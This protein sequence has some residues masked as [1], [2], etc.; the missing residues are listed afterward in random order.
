[1]SFLLIV[2]HLSALAAGAAVTLAFVISSVREREMRSAKVGGALFCVLVMGLVG[3]T[4]LG[5]V[6]AFEGVPGLVL[7]FSGLSLEAAIASLFLRTSRNAKALAGTSGY[8]VDHVERFDERDHVFARNRPPSRALDYYREFYRQHPE[9]EPVDAKRREKGH[10]GSIGSLDRPGERPNVA[11]TLSCL[12]KRDPLGRSRVTRPTPDPRCE[13]TSLKWTPEEATL[14]TKGLLRHLG[15]DLVGITK[16]NPQWVYSHRGDM[17]G[18]D[19]AEWGAE[20]GIEH[21]YAIVFA[22]EMSAEMVATAPHTPSMVETCNVYAKMAL[23]ATEMAGFISNLGYSASANHVGYYETVL[24]PLAV[25]AGL[26]EVGR[27]G[28]LMTAQFG[29][30][31]RLAC[32]TTDLPLVVDR[33]I[34]IGVEDF[35]RV[36]KKCAN[37]CP[38]KSI[39]T[40]DLTVVN[41]SLR[42]KLNAETCFEQWARFGTDCNVCMRVCPWSHRRTWPHRMI[43]WLA[44]RN[45]W[46]RRVLSYL[47]DVFYG[48]HP[49]PAAPPPWAE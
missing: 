22:V 33:P 45:G 17:H 14:R 34:D 9:L 40:D 41:G 38:S 23:M 36:C 25:D 18:G 32:V 1:M 19:T 44:T 37:C 42:W 2:I 12:S 24:V 27:L 13:T 8:L 16:L 47:D 29:P 49:R 15:A 39:P 4:A 35:C 7:L 46:A 5:Y 31:V 10:L 48:R 3:L 21:D 30:R 43:T 28:F 11:A 20:I 26:G 6:G